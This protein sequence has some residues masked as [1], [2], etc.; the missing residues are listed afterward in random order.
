[1]TL[2]ESKALMTPM[3]IESLKRTVT[4][5]PEINISNK[6]NMDIL[7]NALCNAY[8]QNIFHSEVYTDKL[9]KLLNSETST[10]SQSKLEELLKDI[11]KVQPNI[12][13]KIS[14]YTAK[15]KLVKEWIFNGEEPVDFNCIVTF[16]LKYFEITPILVRNNL[17]NVLQKT[18]VNNLAQLVSKYVNNEDISDLKMSIMNIARLVNMSKHLIYANFIELRK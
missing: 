18:I 8:E 2:E 12:V 5:Q 1:M 17:I 9:I 14:I 6:V 7:M 16:V 13:C 15:D 11:H 4:I 10:L 3:A